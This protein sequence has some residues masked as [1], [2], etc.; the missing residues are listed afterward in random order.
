MYDFQYARIAA[1]ILWG[2]TFSIEVLV[3]R[4]VVQWLA[5]LPSNQATRVRFQAW[6]YSRIIVHQPLASR[7]HCIVPTSNGLFSL[8]C[9]L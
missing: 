5:D 8:R 2:G 1:V 7:D 9:L 3:G 4:C 6:S